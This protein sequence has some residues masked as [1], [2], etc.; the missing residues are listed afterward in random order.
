M[1]TRSVGPP[2]TTLGAPHSRISR[3]AHPS[4]E[5]G[6]VLARATDSLAYVDTGPVEAVCVDPAEL[7]AET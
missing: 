5:Q 6:G 1:A 2:T 4:E 3:G 7:T